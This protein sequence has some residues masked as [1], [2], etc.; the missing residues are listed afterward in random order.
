MLPPAVPAMGGATVIALER[1]LGA[2]RLL[3]FWNFAVPSAFLAIA[4]I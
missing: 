3:T 1:S 4:F 2:R